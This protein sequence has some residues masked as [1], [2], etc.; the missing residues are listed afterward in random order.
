MANHMKPLAEEHEELRMRIE[1]IRD[2]AD[3]IGELSIG[4]LRE[5]IRETHEFLTHHL[6]PH[7][8]AEDE[9][10]YPVVARIMGAPRATAT[11]SRDHVAVVRLTEELETIGAH[12]ATTGPRT[13]QEHVLRRILYGLHALVSNHF[14]KE[15]EIYVPILDAGV[16]E[17]EASEIFERMAQAELMA[18]ERASEREHPGSRTLPAHTTSDQQRPQGMGV[19][20]G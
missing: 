3:G 2:I 16:S 18:R 7:A 8:L 9:V 17:S 13:L 19:A 5:R 14:A 10:L 15:E 6:I 4:D 12:L 20:D 1:E 11:M